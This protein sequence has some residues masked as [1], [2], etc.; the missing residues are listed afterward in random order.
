[1]GT[2]LIKVQICLKFQVQNLMFL[3]KFKLITTK[4]ALSCYRC[5]DRDER[6]LRHDLS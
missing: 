4:Q 6:S 2:N 5:V 1:M 3:Q